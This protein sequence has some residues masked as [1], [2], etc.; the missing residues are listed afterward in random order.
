LHAALCLFFT[1]LRLHCCTRPSVGRGG[2]NWLLAWWLVAPACIRA[3]GHRLPSPAIVIRLWRPVVMLPSRRYLYDLCAGWRTSVV[4]AV[5]RVCCAFP[6]AHG[7][8]KRRGKRCCYLFC[9]ATPLYFLLCS[10][11]I[12]Y[13]QGEE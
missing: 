8:I 11:A 7:A 2:E 13:R 9:I 6:A 1:W 4:L 12:C 5:L 3:D 10:I